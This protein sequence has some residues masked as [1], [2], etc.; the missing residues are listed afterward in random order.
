MNI[1]KWYNRFARH[2]AG[3]KITLANATMQ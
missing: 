1:D 3:N 2:L